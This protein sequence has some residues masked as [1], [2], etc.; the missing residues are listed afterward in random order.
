MQKKGTTRKAGTVS[1]CG[2]EG[3]GNDW[4]WGGVTGGWHSSPALVRVYPKAHCMIILSAI[5][6]SF[7]H[8]S[9]L[10]FTMKVI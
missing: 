1:S 7:F 4:G 8:F 3:R 10:N 6:F 5:Q 9:V 2:Q